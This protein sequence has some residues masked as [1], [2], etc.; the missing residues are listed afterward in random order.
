VI[1]TAGKVAGVGAVAWDR[2]GGHRTPMVRGVGVPLREQPAGSPVVR[3][4]AGVFARL[5][6]PDAE[7]CDPAAPEWLVGEESHHDRGA[8][9]QRLRTTQPLR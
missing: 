9:G 7:R 6:R 8:A 3:P 2:A 5:C 1:I 4:A